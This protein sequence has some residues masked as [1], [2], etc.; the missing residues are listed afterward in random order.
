MESRTEP[1]RWLGSLSSGSKKERGPLGSKSLCK[2]GGK[3]CVIYRIETLDSFLRIICFCLMLLMST[4]IVIKENEETWCWLEKKKN[5]PPKIPAKFNQ[6]T[7]KTLN[8]VTRNELNHSQIKFF[9]P[10]GKINS[11]RIVQLERKKRLVNKS[12]K[13]PRWNQVL[14]RRFFRILGKMELS[15]KEPYREAFLFFLPFCL[16]TQ[17]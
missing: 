1:L 13:V 9:E 11:N 4:Y 3:Q 6:I 2:D 14:G 5:S 15:S 16:E 8:T 10:L 7:S 17:S 12:N